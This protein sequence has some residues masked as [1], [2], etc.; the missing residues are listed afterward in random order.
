MPPPTD[1]PKCT[2]EINHSVGD[3]RAGCPYRLQGEGISSNPTAAELRALE[4]LLKR[5][6]THHLTA[7]CAFGFLADPMYQCSCGYEE[8]RRLLPILSALLVQNEALA[9]ELAEARKVLDRACWCPELWKR[10]G[11]APV[12]A[13]R[14]AALGEPPRE[15]SHE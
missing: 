3:H 10:P 13:E 2:C 8:V 9:R 7:E 12:C 1:P 5:V 14:R 6:F 11:H 15:E 4:A